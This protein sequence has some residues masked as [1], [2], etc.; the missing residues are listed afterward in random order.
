MIFTI[1]RSCHLDRLQ[2]TEYRIDFSPNAISFPYK[3]PIVPQL[4]IVGCARFPRTRL[5]V[6]ERVL[7]STESAVAVSTGAKGLPTFVLI[8]EDITD[9]KLEVVESVLK[10]DE[11]VETVNVVVLPVVKEVVELVVMPSGAG[12]DVPA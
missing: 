5:L 6:S 8:A 2:G 4:K 3:Y 7:M 10:R 9:N 12:D 1:K 11:V